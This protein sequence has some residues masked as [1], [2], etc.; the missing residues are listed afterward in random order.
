MRTLVAAAA[1]KEDACP[2]V[3]DEAENMRSASR[4]LFILRMAPLEAC[5]PKYPSQ[6]RKIFPSLTVSCRNVVHQVGHV[7]GLLRLQGKVGNGGM[8][9]SIRPQARKSVAPHAEV[10]PPNGP[11]SRGSCVLSPSHTPPMHSALQRNKYIIMTQR[12]YN[13]NNRV[14]YTMVN[15]ILYCT[16]FLAIPAVYIYTS[17]YIQTV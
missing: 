10:P 13:D 12:L 1:V 4:N 15:Q 16:C 7:E 17:I 9:A 3:T 6:P 8:P 11:S 14:S 2:E 5:F